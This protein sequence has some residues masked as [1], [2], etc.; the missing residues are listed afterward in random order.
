MALTSKPIS[1]G[2]SAGKIFTTV[3][4]G[5]LH[6]AVDNRYV[7]SVNSYN[8][9]VTQTV[10]ALWGWSEKVTINNKTRHVDKD[11]Y[12]AFL[13]ANTDYTGAK[14]DNIKDYV[15]FNA[16]RI[17]PMQEKGT[18][19]QNISHSK[20]N[21]LF[22]K[23]ALA[24]V[25]RGDYEKAA[26]LVGKGADLN[27]RF[28]VRDGQRI[29]FTDLTSGLYRE[30]AVEFRAGLYTPLLY[31]AAVNNQFFTNYVCHF[32]PDLNIQGEILKFERK[33][34]NV[35]PGWTEVTTEEV[36]SHDT[37]NV[38]RQTVKASTILQMQDIKTPQYFIQFNP[39]DH[40]LIWI[41]NRD[42]GTIENYDHSVVTYSTKSV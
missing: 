5:R 14:V 25:E 17:E 38:T 29:S 3:D 22:R 8:N 15:D 19:R 28:W 6:V 26:T 24:I 2:H 40:S 30:Q 10:A 16:M 9:W 18:M 20:A 41:E 32:N 39:E 35:S 37:H 27:T 13:N 34:V 7:G 1:A 21:W 12:I 11:D 23:L 33:I 31:A 36:E 4:G 42:R